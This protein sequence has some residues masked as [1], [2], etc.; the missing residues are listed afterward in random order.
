MA[1]VHN[2][3]TASNNLSGYDPVEGETDG[4]TIGKTY[5]VWQIFQGFKAFD[6]NVVMVSSSGDTPSWLANE[7]GSIMSE[8]EKNASTTNQHIKWFYKN[9]PGLSG[10][11]P[12]AWVY[13]W[14]TTTDVTLNRNLISV[15]VRH[16]TSGS[17]PYVPFSSGSI[18]VNDPGNVDAPEQDMY[19]VGFNTST[20]TT[21]ALIPKVLFWKSNN[22]TTLM[23]INK[24]DGTYEGYLTWYHPEYTGYRASV[25]GS[26][27]QGTDFN[28]VA[29]TNAYTGNTWVEAFTQQF[30]TLL[31]QQVNGMSL[32]TS[33][34]TMPTI[35]F[36]MGTDLSLITG[37]IRIGLGGEGA[38]FKAI[39]DEIEGLYYCNVSAVS[40]LAGTI[41]F[42][43]SKY[44]LVLNTLET[45]DTVTTYLVRALLELGT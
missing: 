8:P 39:S 2:L 36:N 34:G 42:L 9:D 16:I 33:A 13:Q 30:G 41:I 27:T 1:I 31:S 5:I 19:Q 29:F 44:Y 25:S 28:A 22:A 40:D 26:F 6:T 15:A 18:V 23:G 7:S 11:I 43:N 37:K 35:K 38:H 20:T 21:M 32:V 17:S 4:T 14:G 12:N 45:A 10:S 3:A 24:S